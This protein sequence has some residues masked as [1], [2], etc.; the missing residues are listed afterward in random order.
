LS[1]ATILAC[2]DS[3]D[4]WLGNQKNERQLGQYRIAAYYND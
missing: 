4:L 2:L 3:I 1:V